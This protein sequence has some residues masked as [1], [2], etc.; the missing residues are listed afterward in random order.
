MKRIRFDFSNMFS[1]NVGSRHGVTEAELKK[2]AGAPC[3]RRTGISK[4]V[5]G[6]IRRRPLKKELRFIIS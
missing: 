1:H 2:I 3:G 4:E 6:E 5:V